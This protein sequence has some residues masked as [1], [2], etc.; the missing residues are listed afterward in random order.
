[1]PRELSRRDEMANH[2]SAEVA[3]WRQEG[4]VLEPFSH[5][6]LRIVTTADAQGRGELSGQQ[7]RTETTF[8]DFQTE[9]P[10]GMAA[11]TVPAGQEADK[12]ESGLDDL[13]RYV[14]QTTPPTVPAPGEKPVMAKPFYRAFDVGVAFDED[15][16]DLMYRLSGRD[17]GLYLY[18]ASNR[19]V[20]DAEGRLLVQSGEWGAAE[21]L[22]LT[23]G[24]ERW[25]ALSESGNGCLPVIDRSTIVRDRTLVSAVAGRV[26]DAD[27]VYEA[28]L[29][30]LLLRDFFSGYPLGGAAQGPAGRLGRWEVHDAGSTGGPSHWEVRETAAP[31]ARYLAQTSTIASGGANPADPALPGTVLFFGADPSLAAGHLE[32]PGA[33]TDYRLSAWVRA[34][35]GAAGVVFRWQS[36][37]SHYRF[38]FDC[39]TPYRRLVSVAGGALTVLAEDAFA[40]D[41]G[42][43]YLLSVEVVGASLRVYQDG[44]LVFSVADAAHAQGGVGV[45][46]HD[47]PDARF[48]DVRVDD[49]RQAARP[50]YRFQF[51][52]SLY[53]NFFHHLHGYHD[54]T[55]RV[56]VDGN[57][58][59]GALPALAKGV[60]P[61]TPPGEDEARAYATLADAVLGPEARRNPREVQVTR[62]EVDGAP[63][64]FLLRSPE[65]L[66]W[67]RTDLAL[68]RTPFARTEPALPG[69]VKLATAAFAPGR[70]RIEAVE[71]L[72][73]E[74]VSLAGYRIE[75]RVVAWPLSPESGVVLDAQALAQ[76][77]AAAHAWTPYHTFG[78][79]E[80]VPAGTCVRALSSDPTAPAPLVGINAESIPRERRV[81]FSVEARVVAPDGAVIHARHFLPDDD[82]VPQDVRVLRKADGTGVFLMMP[83]TSPG[84]TPFPLAQYRL[85]LSYRR[86]NRARVPGSPVWSQ[87]GGTAAEAVT[88]DIPLQTQPS[89]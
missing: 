46:A 47:D 86:D 40:C 61:S 44:A 87:A 81:F 64:A 88:L 28:R 85:K 59:A 14:R 1:M 29:I 27:T 18:D 41:A 73:R 62:V 53:A 30:P 65:P 36:A 48:A 75:T 84:A 17:L 50:V 77:T 20:R 74:P 11:L 8:F 13:T 82:Y 57:D 12:F 38:S 16:V 60:P 35:G 24:E 33:W 79:A 34:G 6:R 76:H 52:T 68:W 58:V 37:A 45:Y 25:V 89:A 31:A 78:P 56:A 83:S 21:E 67:L 26:L 2:L 39:T 4:E 66:D 54:E 5:Y 15:Y 10:P 51:T 72:A 32:Q 49:F 70:T 22:T 43:D 23:E 7:Y 42:R 69:G 63:L 19:P 9:G 3:R 55:W 71:V 80:K